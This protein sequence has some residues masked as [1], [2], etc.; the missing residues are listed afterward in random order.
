VKAAPAVS[1]RSGVPPWAHAALGL[2]GAAALGTTLPWAASGGGG[3]RWGA[4][5][6]TLA[7]TLHLL[8]GLRSTLVR[9][10][11]WDG[12]AWWLQ[13]DR[14]GTSEV[15]GE[16]AVACDLGTVLLLHF[17]E[18]GRP[19]WARGRWMAIDRRQVEGDWHGLR[20]A[21]YAPRP[22]RPAV[23]SELLDG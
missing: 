2:L 13:F 14:S 17:S 9:R 16:V 20:S 18:A 8:A 10:L 7:L 6:A 5:L 1:V 12:A 23:A 19:R 4:P 22:A 3:L 21:L 11:R 15:Q